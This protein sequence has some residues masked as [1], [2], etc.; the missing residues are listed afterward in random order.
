MEADAAFAR[1]LLEIRCDIAKTQCHGSPEKQKINVR[2]DGK[3]R[4]PA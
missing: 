1:F 4:E 3:H 2:N